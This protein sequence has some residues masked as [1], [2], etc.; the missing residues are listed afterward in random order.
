[1]CYPW[2]YIFFLDHAGRKIWNCTDHS[3]LGCLNC[4]P[5]FGEQTCSLE[6]WKKKK[7]RKAMTHWIWVFPFRFP[8]LLTGLCWRAWRNEIFT[9][10]TKWRTCWTTMTLNR[11][12]YNHS[13]IL[14][15]PLL[16]ILNKRY[17]LGGGGVK[18]YSTVHL[19][20]SVLTHRCQ[21][22]LPMEPSSMVTLTWGY[23]IAENWTW[24]WT[25]SEI[26]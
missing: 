24:N 11:W 17:F 1:M 19:L 15:T 25:C 14:H 2:Q 10:G 3:E 12:V 4:I 7:E 23:L 21:W 22:E 26:N 5:E 20:L 18:H 6:I 9:W 13:H 16:V 8:W